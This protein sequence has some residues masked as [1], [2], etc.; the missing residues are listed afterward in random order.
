MSSTNKPKSLDGFVPTS[1]NK[2]RKGHKRTVAGLVVIWVL[3]L[4]VIASI[5]F[6]SYMV[7]FGTSDSTAKMLILPQVLFAGLALIALPAL[8]LNKIL[9]DK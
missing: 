3:V 2:T 1:T 4:T 6:S 7:Y 5:G 8:A 9:S